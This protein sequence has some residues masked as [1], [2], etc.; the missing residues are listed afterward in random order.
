MENTE[1][2]VWIDFLQCCGYIDTDMQI[3]L[4]GKTE[5]IGRLLS[6]MIKNP[7]RFVWKE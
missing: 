6:Y 1:T 2:M 7:E 5:E 4:Y 3:Q